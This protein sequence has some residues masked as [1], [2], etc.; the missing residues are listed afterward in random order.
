M[1]FGPVLQIGELVVAE[2]LADK[3]STDARDREVGHAVHVD[4]RIGQ[5]LE[6]HQDRFIAARAVPV[7]TGLHGRSRRRANGHGR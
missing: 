5:L 4:D 6:H 3:D 2:P 1:L 7:S